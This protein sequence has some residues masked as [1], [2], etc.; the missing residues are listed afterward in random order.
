M[1]KKK[2]TQWNRSNGG[3]FYPEELSLFE[4]EFQLREDLCDS[5]V[6][7]GVL[8]M[9]EYPAD[10]EGN[11]IREKGRCLVAGKNLIVDVGRASL[12]SL[13]R[14]TAASITTIGTFDLGYLAIGSGSSGGATTPQPAD[15]GLTTEDTDPV[16]G[17]V[18]SGVPRPTLQVS[19]P[20][21]TPFKV[22]LWTAQ[23]GTTQLNG[24]DIDEAGLFCLDDTTLF[25]KRAFAAQ[26]K[27]S[28]FVVEFRWSIL[29]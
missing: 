22:N 1:D 24:T 17:P 26:T 18:V 16:G 28:G 20:S 5:Q 21:P 27:A 2:V 23:L 8:S 9:F 19:T 4:K 15:T 12:A 13:Q 6:T 14:T 11:P 3:I 25:A 7:S 29:F 10:D